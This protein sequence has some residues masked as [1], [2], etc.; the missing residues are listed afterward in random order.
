MRSSASTHNPRPRSAL[1]LLIVL[2]GEDHP[3]ACTGRRLLRWGRVERASREDSGSPAP[4]VLDP[5]SPTP[6]SGAD[7]AAVARGGL[8]VVDCS[9]NR[10]SARGAFPGSERTGRSRTPHR[11]LPVLVATNPQHYGR[12]AQLNTVEA[13]CAALYVLGRP[14]E[15]Q[16]VIA[17]FAGGDEF[18][19]VNRDR[20]ESY[21]RA[22][23][24]GEIMVAEKTLFGA[25]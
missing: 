23:A 20:L 19:V 5:Y 21:S 12:V 18:L 24:P 16:K 3:K 25:T 10:L 11:R 15:A 13:L 1:R 2:A 17:G 9:W 22:V 14:D 8:L 6:L 4:V 7:R